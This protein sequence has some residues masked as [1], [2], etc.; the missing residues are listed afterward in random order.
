MKAG[1]P[2]EKVVL[3]LAT[4]GRPFRL[5]SAVNNGLHA[6]KSRWESPRTGKYTRTTGS[7]SYYEICNV[8]T[9]VNENAAGAPYGYTGTDWCGFDT[10]DSLIGKVKSLVIGKY[11]LDHVVF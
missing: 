4:Y 6:P 11:I 5:E 8:Y 1:F 3:G 9:M 2:A 7:L 10:R